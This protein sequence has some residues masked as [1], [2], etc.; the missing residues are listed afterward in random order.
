[1]NDPNI[2]LV[3]LETFCSEYQRFQQAPKQRLL[4]DMKSFFARYKEL[5]ENQVSSNTPAAE[6]TPVFSE[7]QYNLFFTEFK[8]LYLGEK[9]RG[10]EINVWG[11]SGLKQDEVRNT[12]V[13]T[14]WLDCNGSHGLGDVL[15]KALLASLPDNNVMPPKESIDC[16]YRVQAESLPLGERENRIDIELSHADFLIFVEVK[17]NA[18]E[19]YE[20]L[21]RYR[22]LIEKK[23]NA[24]GMA[25]GGI[26]YLTRYENSESNE[27]GCINLSWQQL[28]R[29][30]REASLPEDAILSKMLLMQFCEHIESL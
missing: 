19:G 10:A 5:I 9:R 3:E 29:S 21:S 23:K 2:S 20:Q 14:W 17:I 8:P 30:F 11:E 16:G 24:Y 22:A 15:L 18:T 4:N 1:M 27:T 13:L 6:S 12:A 25:Y 28:A 7:Q 26:I